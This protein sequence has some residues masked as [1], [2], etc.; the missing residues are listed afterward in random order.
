MTFW[1]TSENKFQS[2]KISADDLNNGE[3]AI[4]LKGGLKLV[5]PI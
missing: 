4:I 3:K 1:G 5:A 2:K